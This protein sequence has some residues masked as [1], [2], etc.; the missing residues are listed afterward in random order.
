MYHGI[1]Y[2]LAAVS[3][4]GVLLGQAT[5]EGSMAAILG[6]GENTAAVAR[7]GTLFRERCGS[8]HGDTAKGTDAVPGLIRSAPLQNDEHGEAL[9]PILRQ[10]H[11]PPLNLS[12][13]QISD[14]IAWLRVQLYA[15]ANRATYSYLDIVTGDAK[16]GAEFFNGA[17]KCGSC[18]SP[19]GD[20]AGVGHRYDPPVLQA[21]WL[22][23]SRR[24]FARGANGGVSRSMITVKVGSYSGTLDRIDDFTVALRDAGN[25]LRVIPITPGTKVEI[26][27]PLKD[28]AELIPKLT[29]A[30]IHDVTAYLV[31]LQ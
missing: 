7:G 6:S 14:V 10:T 25:V 20:L 22:N 30:V 31:T 27:D 4:S 8:C 19:T 15:A 9:T 21:L 5:V 28:H 3:L 11:R 24:R 17:G 18:H 13:G 2:A 12:A 16:R 29:D 1:R 26:T 23:P